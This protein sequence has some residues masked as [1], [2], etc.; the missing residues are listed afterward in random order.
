MIVWK[1]LRVDCICFY[2]EVALWQKMFS[3]L[4]DFGKE[5]NHRSDD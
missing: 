4:K 3:S 1:G 2:K 5:G